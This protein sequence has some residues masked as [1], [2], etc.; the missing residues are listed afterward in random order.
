VNQND[1]VHGFQLPSFVQQFAGDFDADHPNRDGRRQRRYSQAS[2]GTID[3]S[4]ESKRKNNESRASALLDEGW[5]QVEIAKELNIS[6]G[7]V[8]QST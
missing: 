3:W 7:R 2:D 5:K 8:S 6:K 1:V 4:Y